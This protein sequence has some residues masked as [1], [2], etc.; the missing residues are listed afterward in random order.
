MSAS[1]EPVTTRTKQLNGI[2][3]TIFE[4]FECIHEM[5]LNWKHEYHMPFIEQVM[6][7]QELEAALYT[8]GY[9]EDFVL[10]LKQTIYYS[11]FTG[12]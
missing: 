1:R 6:R 4:V 5:L 3:D 7:L 8:L 12:K 10:T 9:D 11:V 2:A